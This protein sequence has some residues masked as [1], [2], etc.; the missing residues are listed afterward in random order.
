[1]PTKTTYLLPIVILW[2]LTLGL[3]TWIVH[4]IAY[5]FT[6]T[7]LTSWK[8][9]LAVS[10]MIMGF[11][12]LFSGVHA[13]LA[14]IFCHWRGSVFELKLPADEISKTL[15]IRV[16]AILALFA[17]VIIVFLGMGLGLP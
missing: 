1:M 6:F 7:W 3:Q 14:E 12:D 17:V 11:L 5:A 10:V 2:L 4:T 9:S 15:A 13:R 8:M 16:L